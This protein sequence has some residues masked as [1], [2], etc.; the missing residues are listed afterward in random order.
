MSNKKDPKNEKKKWE[1]PSITKMKLSQTLK[2]NA[3]GEESH[4]SAS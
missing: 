2:H 4:E 1:K 3:G